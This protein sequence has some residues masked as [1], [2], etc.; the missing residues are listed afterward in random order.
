MLMNIHKIN[1][2]PVAP[3]EPNA[4]YIYPDPDNAAKVIIAFASA[5]GTVIRQTLSIDNVDAL[6]DAKIT[7]FAT[8]F[9]Q[10]YSVTD[11]DELDPLVTIAESTNKT[12]WV[13]VADPRTGS[14]NINGTV[15]T[16][17]STVKSGYALYAYNPS[18]NTWKKIG[19]GES[20]DFVFN[21]GDII[22]KPAWIAD[23]SVGANDELLYKGAPLGNVIFKTPEW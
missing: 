9:G 7:G 1:I 20:M 2:A 6:I 23:I 13:Y 17:D 3:Y 22:G 19:E 16:G 12:V 10:V 11:L 4:M 14:A 21:W 18:V 15:V 5:D 8:S